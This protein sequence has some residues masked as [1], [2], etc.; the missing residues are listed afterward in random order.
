MRNL[1]K[2][3]KFSLPKMWFVDACI[4]SQ[5]Y[6]KMLKHALETFGDHGPR[7]SGAGRE[8]FPQQTK[9]RLRDKANW[10]TWCSEMAWKSK[11][12]RVHDSTMR[13]LATQCANK[14]GCGFY[15]PQ[16]DQ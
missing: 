9:Q 2:D 4:A 15:G 7:V 13:K 8:H 1:Y 10:V 3:V 16:A 6:D 11:P 5:Q 14:H 12:K